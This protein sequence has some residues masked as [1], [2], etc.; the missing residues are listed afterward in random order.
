MYDTVV[1]KMYTSDDQDPDKYRYTWIL[2]K[3]DNYND[4]A[5][6]SESKLLM[7]YTKIWYD[8]N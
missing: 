2:E 1:N 7:P 4:N 5:I 8:F 6:F 3:F